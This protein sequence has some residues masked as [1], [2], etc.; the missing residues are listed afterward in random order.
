MTVFQN[1]AYNIQNISKQNMVLLDYNKRKEK[2]EQI[3][4]TLKILGI[5][6]GFILILYLFIHFF[7]NKEN[8]V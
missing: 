1:D 8:F 5:I 6:I 2:I 3:K 4:T 7:G